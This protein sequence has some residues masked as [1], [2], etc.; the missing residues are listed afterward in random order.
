MEQS[1]AAHHACCNTGGLDFSWIL[2]SRCT[3]VVSGTHPC[4]ASWGMDA[5]F[6]RASIHHCRLVCFLV[7]ICPFVSCWSDGQAQPVPSMAVLEYTK[8]ETP[9]FGKV[10]P[11]SRPFFPSSLQKAPSMQSPGRSW[12]CPIPPMAQEGHPDNPDTTGSKEQTQRGVTPP[13]LAASLL[14]P[15]MHQA[16]ASH[17]MGKGVPSSL[18]GCAWHFVPARLCGCLPR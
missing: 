15:P 10:Q 13:W 17:G 6:P 18:Q 11:P 12:G 3:T 7:A 1:C 8:D 9:I 2:Q 4:R 16:R 5:L 14:L